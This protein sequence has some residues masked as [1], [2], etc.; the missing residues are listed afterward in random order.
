MILYIAG[1][2][3]GLKDKGRE[4][5]TRAEVELMAAGHIVLNPAKLPDGMRRER[6][7]PICMAM[8]DAADGVYLLNNWQ[9]SLGARVEN[10]YATYQHKQILY[11][12]AGGRL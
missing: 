11:E 9:D 4:H 7:M 1:K 6:Y 5:F 12:G 3:A 2:M 8:I 10:A